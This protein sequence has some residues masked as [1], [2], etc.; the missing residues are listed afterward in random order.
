MRISRFSIPVV[1]HVSD[2][3]NLAGA[4]L[5]FSC[6][7]AE[8]VWSDLGRRRAQVLATASRG[9]EGDPSCLSQCHLRAAQPNRSRLMCT[10]VACLWSCRSWE[11]K[12]VGKG[13]PITG[14][15][16]GCGF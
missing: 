1:L 6:L 13:H 14:A 2:P 12:A 10:I 5:P 3:S 15:G 7:C 8:G 9:T 11:Y 16:H 4:P